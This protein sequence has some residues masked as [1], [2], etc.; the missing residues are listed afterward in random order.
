MQVLMAK[1][2]IAWLPGDGSEAIEV[3]PASQLTVTN[4]AKTKI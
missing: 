1:S 3:A 2:R 4:L